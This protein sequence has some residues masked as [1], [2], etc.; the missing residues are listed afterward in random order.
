MVTKELKAL[1]SRILAEKGVFEKITAKQAKAIIREAEAGLI[2]T[3]QFISNEAKEL[4]GGAKSN[5]YCNIYLCPKGYWAG[6]KGHSF[7]DS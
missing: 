5:E 3:S 2:K 4:H 6:T 1:A 7:C